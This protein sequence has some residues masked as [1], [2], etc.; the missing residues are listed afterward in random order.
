MSKKLRGDLFNR[1]YEYAKNHYPE[2]SAEFKTAVTA[3]MDANRKEKEVERFVINEIEL[4]YT[5][6]DVRQKLTTNIETDNKA[7]MVIL[8]KTITKAKAIKLSGYE[9][10]E[11]ES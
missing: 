1:A 10:Y 9:R 6:G 3:Y 11:K 4:A 5:K 8:I 7:K 2:G